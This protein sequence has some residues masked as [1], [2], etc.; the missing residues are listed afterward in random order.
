[1]FCFSASPYRF[2]FV[3]AAVMAAVLMTAPALC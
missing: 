1:M 3:L 2:V